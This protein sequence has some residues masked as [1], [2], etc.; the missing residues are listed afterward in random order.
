MQ[1]AFSHTDWRAPTAWSAMVAP[2]RGAKEAKIADKQSAITT[3]TI[4]STTTSTTTTIT[5][6]SSYYN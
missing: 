1:I 2:E 3:T 4:T 6:I 5:T